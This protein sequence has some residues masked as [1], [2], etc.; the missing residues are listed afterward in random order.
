MGAVDPLDRQV[1]GGEELGGLV[2][3]RLVIKLEAQNADRGLIRLH[4]HDAVVAA[5]LHCAQINALGVF[6]RHLQPKR[7]HVEG[8]GSG[9]IGHCVFH[10]G[11]QHDVEGG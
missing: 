9:K 5:F 3:I 6:M 4:Q 2:Q 7:V 11:Q 1:L 10:M 8:A